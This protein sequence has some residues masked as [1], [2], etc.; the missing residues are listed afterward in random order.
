MTRRCKSS[1]DLDDGNS[2]PNS[3]GDHREV[4][5]GGSCRR[6][7]GPRDTKRI[8][9]MESLGKVAWCTEPESHPEADMYMRRVDGRKVM[10][11]TPGDLAFCP[12]GLGKSEGG[13][14]GRQK[15]A[16]AI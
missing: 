13:P 9:G 12:E 2:K 3:K 6:T 11:I 5:S 8:R 4:V 1:G 10:R 16:G 14:M 15:S 7:S